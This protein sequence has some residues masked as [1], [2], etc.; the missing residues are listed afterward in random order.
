M[1]LPKGRSPLPL[2]ACVGGLGQAL[3]ASCKVPC[4]T[5]HSDGE[6]PTVE[7]AYPRRNLLVRGGG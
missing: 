6:R 2:D 7:H 5:P 4:A 3:R 1:E